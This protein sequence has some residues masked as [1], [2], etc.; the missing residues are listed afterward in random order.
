VV[1]GHRWLNGTVTRLVYGDRDDPVRA[2]DRVGRHL[3]SREATDLD[4]IAHAV[5]DA[6]RSPRVEIRDSEGGEVGRSGDLDGLP[7]HEAPLH[8]AGRFV[9]TLCVAWRT[10]A[11]RFS[12]ADLRLIDTLAAPVAVALSAAVLAQELAGSHARIIAVR[13][14][15]RRALRNDLHDGLGP[16]LSGVALGIEAALKA[17]DDANVKEILGVVHG[18]VRTLVGEVRAIIEDLGHDAAIHGGLLSALRSHA[19]AVGT[20]TGLE[21][22]VRGDELPA[23]DAAVEAALHRIATEAL[24]NVVRH[25]RASHVTVCLEVD[26]AVLRL[27]VA[28]DGRGLRGAP[29]GVGRASMRERARA[30]GG[31]L[32]ITTSDRGGTVVT[33]EV[34][35]RLP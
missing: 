21:V 12:R 9:G 28:D 32:D 6:L 31:R 13:D 14:T 11:D 17:P 33:A 7:M 2:L 10:A 20:L 35:W 3:G 16:A 29:E 26:D 30:V 25:A 34:P 4:A 15:E 22:T 8:H 24:T 19:S 5:A 18:E 23:V 27:S 1:P